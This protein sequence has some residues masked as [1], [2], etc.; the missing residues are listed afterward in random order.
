MAEARRLLLHEEL[1]ELLGS[2]AV[3]Y[4][5]PESL[6]MDYPC[7]RYSGSGFDTMYA[8]N[9]PYKTIKRYEGIII[10]PDPDSDIPELMLNQF[11]MCNVSSTY[12]ANNLYHHPFTLYY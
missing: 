4:Q 3:Y 1:C 11:E 9:R 10:T 6:K 5:P 8:D 2:R 12:V 7:I